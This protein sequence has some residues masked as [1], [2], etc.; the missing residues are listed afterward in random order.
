[1]LDGLPIANARVLR[2]I[3]ALD[4]AALGAVSRWRFL[5]T[6]L[7]GQPVGVLMTVTVNFALQ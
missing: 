3:P 1:M 5:P 6:Q 2:S 7:N 4:Q